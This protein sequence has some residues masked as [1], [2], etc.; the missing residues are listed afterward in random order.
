MA[1][2]FDFLDIFIPEIA[3]WMAGKS[4]SEKRRF[5][6]AG[7][8]LSAIGAAIAGCSYFFPE[9]SELVFMDLVWSYFIAFMFLCC[10]IGLLTCTYIDR[11]TTSKLNISHNTH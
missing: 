9:I 11:K 8:G 6:N 3:H 2:P 10:G 1:F 7:V 5:R 4:T